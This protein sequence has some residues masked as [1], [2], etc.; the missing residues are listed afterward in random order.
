MDGIQWLDGS[1]ITCKGTEGDALFILDLLIFTCRFSNKK[2]EISTRVEGKLKGW[3]MLRTVDSGVHTTEGGLV[4][5]TGREWGPAQSPWMRH[6]RQE[7][8]RI[9]GIGEEKKIIS[10]TNRN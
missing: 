4:R 6:F 7:D 3:K 5:N 1:D 9:Q 2:K 10:E 8:S